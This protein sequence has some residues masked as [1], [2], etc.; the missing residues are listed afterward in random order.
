MFLY[1]WLDWSFILAI[2][3]CVYYQK[4]DVT[5]K[6]NIFTVHCTQQGT[7][8]CPSSSMQ[9]LF[10]PQ[11]RRWAAQKSHLPK[12]TQDDETADFFLPQPTINFN[13]FFPYS[14]YIA[15]SIQWFVWFSHWTKMALEGTKGI[16]GCLQEDKL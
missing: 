14:S 2:R 3:F 9:S 7:F 11:L 15:S 5:S 12:C 13:T 1:C 4:L 6:K 10:I 8:S 16:R